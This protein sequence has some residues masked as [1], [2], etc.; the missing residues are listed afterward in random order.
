MHVV[1][2]FCGYYPPRWLEILRLP[3]DALLT[4]GD[5]IKEFWH[6]AEEGITPAY[7]A[8]VAG[9]ITKLGLEEFFQ[10]H[11]RLLESG[12]QAFGKYWEFKRSLLDFIKCRYNYRIT[13]SRF[14]SKRSQKYIPG[15]TQL[16]PNK[17]L[18]V[19]IYCR[20]ANSDG[21]WESVSFECYRCSSA[22]CQWRKFSIEYKIIKL[23]ADNPGVPTTDNMESS[24]SV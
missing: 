13:W 6:N 20:R 3:D 14:S 16:P 12:W 7:Y 24:C 15:E 9:G 5:Q 2:P 22:R 11:S 1:T 23:A 17:P 4:K 18:R 19:G 8:L 10:Q 21:F